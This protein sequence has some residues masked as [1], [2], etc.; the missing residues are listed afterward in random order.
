VTGVRAGRCL[1]LTVLTLAAFNLARS[2]GWLGSAAVS[3]AVLSGLL[4]VIA[5]VCQVS[6][7]DVGLRRAHVASGLRYGGGAAALVLAV[8]VVAAVLPATNGFLHDSRADITFGRLV[9]EIIVQV[10]LLTAIPEEFAFRGLLFGSARR[11]WGARRAAV[12]SSLLFGFWHIA[13][14]LHQASSSSALGRVSKSGG[15]AVL[16]VLGAVTATFVAGLV[17]CWLRERSGSLVAPIIAHMATN[18]F[19]LAVAWAATR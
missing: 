6:L 7:D 1:V 3:A 17:F 8:L 13:P 2:F 16:A 12:L 4:V 10:T 9:D 15:G 19:G 18:G 5:L 11:L 14:T